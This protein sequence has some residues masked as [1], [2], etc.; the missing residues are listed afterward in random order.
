MAKKIKI[1]HSY[2]NDLIHPLGKR[3]PAG[4]MSKRQA[5]SV[6]AYALRFRK[7]TVKV[8]GQDGFF[9]YGFETV[10]DSIIERNR[11]YCLNCGRLQKDDNSKCIICEYDLFTHNKYDVV[12][13]N[14]DK[15]H[16]ILNRDKMPQP[17]DFNENQFFKPKN[18]WIKQGLSK[19]EIHQRRY[20]MALEQWQAQICHCFDELRSD[21]ALSLRVKRDAEKAERESRKR[22]IKIEK[23]DELTFYRIELN[24]LL[25]ADLSGKSRSEKKEISRRKAQLMKILDY[26]T[27]NF[28]KK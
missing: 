28:V 19:Q 10:N 21:Y 25:A 15:P 12:C 13:L 2:F 11:L 5:E 24:R 27:I 6:T 7:D 14:C 20:L 3:Q 9:R 8:N 22:Q 26:P 18:L 1:S 4:A 17:Q 16:Y 23:S